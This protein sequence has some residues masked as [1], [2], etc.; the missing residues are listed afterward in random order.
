MIN[1][2]A[3]LQSPE[4]QE[5]QERMGRATYRAYGVLAIRHDL[6]L[7]SSYLYVP[8]ATPERPT[9]FVQTLTEALEPN[10]PLFIRIDPRDELNV[11]GLFYTR[12]APPSQPDQTVVVDLTKSDAVLA[13]AMHPKT[14]YNIGVAE[15]RGVVV[16]RVQT[17]VPAETFG[18]FFR[19][20]CATAERD[21]FSLHP[22]EH[23]RALLDVHSANFANELWLAE[24]EGVLL[25]VAITNRYMPAATLTYLHGA[26]DY[27]ER[28][29]MAP[30]LLHWT[31]L[32]EARSLAMR[33]YD[34]GGT[35]SK[36]WPGITRFKLGF[37]G[38]P[39]AFP[40]AHD[41]VLRPWWY[42]VYQ[43]QRLLRN[44]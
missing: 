22:R 17:P 19:L 25:A 2:Q 5:I 36:R 13:R 39:F 35:D 12:H 44:R 4:W 38:T 16:R 7:G 34:F 28:R 33:Y 15:R 21:G 27:D 14:R 6:P 11:G 8:R 43:L 42:G 3:F 31:I 10:G 30:H 26:S 40:P 9:E 29:D 23:Y 20:L 37:G 41:I 1:V 24:R 32:K 18:K